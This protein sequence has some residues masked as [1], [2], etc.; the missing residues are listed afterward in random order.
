MKARRVKHLDPAASLCGNAARIVRVRLEELRSFIPAAL[1]PGASEAQH[2]MRIAA[3]RLRYV[4]ELTG[5]CFGERGAAARRGARD[6][7]DVLGD[8][9]DCDV[10]LPMAE[11]QSNLE[12]LVVHL[13]ARRRLRFDGFLELWEKQRRSGVWDELEAAAREPAPGGATLTMER[14]RE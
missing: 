10:M 13:A 5:L 8:L 2:D 3:K 9:H 11:G 6:L 14:S 1:D 4:L 7:Q 12:I